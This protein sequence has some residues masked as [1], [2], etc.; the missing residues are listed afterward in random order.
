MPYNYIY[1]MEADGIQITI[2]KANSIDI[3]KYEG[4]IK[5]EYLKDR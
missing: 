5:R 2:R 1:W 4:I 3:P